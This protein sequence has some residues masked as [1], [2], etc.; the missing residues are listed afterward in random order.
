MVGIKVQ[1]AFITQNT[2]S[3]KKQDPPLERVECL[4]LRGKGGGRGDDASAV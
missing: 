1:K 4:L 2:W 3:D